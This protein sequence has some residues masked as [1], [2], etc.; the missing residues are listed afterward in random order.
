MDKKAFFLSLYS[1]VI[2][3]GL[4]SAKELE[5][6]YNLGRTIYGLTE[7]EINEYIVSADVSYVMPETF[8]DK[9][10]VL[11]HLTMVA[12]ADKNIDDNER[13]LLKR[14]IILYQFE[15]E[16]ADSISDFLIERVK[17]GV[18]F[19]DVLSEINNQ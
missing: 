15:E 5:M 17:T 14:Y 18:K 16:N 11:Y 8:E 19:E 9:I 6:V 3:D 13:A 12:W 1:M 2:A 10:R 7:D 4:V